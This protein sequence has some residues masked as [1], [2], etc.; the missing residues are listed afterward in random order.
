MEHQT[1]Y[2]KYR[3]ETF[4]DV[5][6]QDHVI[7]VLETALTKGSHAHAYLLTGGR[8][9][10]KT[11]IARIIARTLGTS[12]SDMY[13][14][15]AASNRGID[16]IRELRIAVHTLPFDSRYK[17]YIIDEVHMLTKEAF[18]ALLKTLEEPPTHVI[19]ILATTEIEKVPDTI[20][21]RCEVYTFKQPNETV[22]ADHVEKISQKEEIKI[23]RASAE[24]IALLGNGSFRDTLGV[25]QKVITLS[26]DKKLSYDEVERVL[27]IPSRTSVHSILEGLVANNP[28]YILKTL[29]EVIFSGR[30]PDRFYDMVI[31]RVRTLLLLRF[32]GK[33][34]S[35]L[36]TGISESEAIELTDILKKDTKGIFTSRTLQILIEKREFSR[37]AGAPLL[38]LE[39]ALFDILSN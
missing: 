34:S 8:G 2:R 6:G 24:L 37:I 32:G 22:L 7:S 15:D 25:L 18:N 3:P 31:M 30:S 4:T 10:G 1:L 23:D 9:T 19:F 17:V 38:P 36:M 5:V 27:D 26:Q 13:E 14:I 21:S 29:S 39:L 33:Y 16:D 12:D 11:T 28:E 20:V 35:G